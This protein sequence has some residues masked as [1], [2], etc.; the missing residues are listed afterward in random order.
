[1][2][3]GIDEEDDAI[4]KIAISTNCFKSVTVTFPSLILNL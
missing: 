4:E 1:V 2:S 3:L